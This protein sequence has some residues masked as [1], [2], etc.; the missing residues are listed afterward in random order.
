MK[1]IN[2]L[3]PWATMLANGKKQVKA[4]SLWEPWASLVRTGAKGIETRGR[5]TNYRGELLICAA[6]KGLPLCDLIHYMSHWTFQSGLA[7]LVGEPLDMTFKS[8][9]GVKK[10]HLNFGKAVALVN[11]FDC[12][13]T[14]D[15]TLAEIETEKHFGNFNLGRFAWKM[16]LLDGEFEPFPVKGRQG[17][18]NVDIGGMPWL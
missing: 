8:W 3:G 9:P 1:P 17:F 10:E 5:K 4:I 2:L 11:L 16:E 14:D 12:K 6:Q 13:R 7:P 15:L 18:F